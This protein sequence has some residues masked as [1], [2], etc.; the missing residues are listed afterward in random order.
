VS[1]AAF[2]CRVAHFSCKQKHPTST[3]TTESAELQQVQKVWNRIRNGSPIYDFLLQDI[4]LISAT[5]DSMKASLRVGTQHL[6]SKG[7]FHGSVSETLVDW[8]G[9]LA[10][11]AAG[12]DQTGVSVHI[13]VNFVSTAKLGDELEVEGKVLR[14]GGTLAYTTVMITKI[15]TDPP[16]VVSHG[17]HTKYVKP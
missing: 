6:N 4:V 17:S 12:L 10:I 9:G 8:A 16:V 14:L 5:K 1:S 13:D 2:Y 3:M 11:A 7:G 15:G